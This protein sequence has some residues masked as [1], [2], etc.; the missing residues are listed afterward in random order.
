MPDFADI[1]VIMTIQMDE[2][3]EGKI[4]KNACSG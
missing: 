4:T 3:E 1:G 2:Y